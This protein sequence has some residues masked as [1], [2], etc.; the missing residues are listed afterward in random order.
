MRERATV[1]PDGRVPEVADLPKE[2]QRVLARL[3][4]E[5]VL[6]TE[7]GVHGLFHWLY[8]GTTRPDGSRVAWTCQ[9]WE[10]YQFFRQDCAAR[11]VDVPTQPAVAPQ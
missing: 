3:M 1:A 7:G 9:G 5:K 4:L 11:G 8:R 10:G 6:D 2:A